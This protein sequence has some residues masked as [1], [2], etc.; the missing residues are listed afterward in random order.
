MRRIKEAVRH[1]FNWNGGP[2]PEKRVRRNKLSEVDAMLPSGSFKLSASIEHGAFAY[3]FAQRTMRV[4]SSR[5]Q[6]RK[7]D[8]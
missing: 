6:G 5:S 7:S 2:G 1:V 3:Q 8:G 4:G